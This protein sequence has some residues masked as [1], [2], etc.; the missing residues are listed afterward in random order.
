L[1]YLPGTGAGSVDNFTINGTWS[2]AGYPELQADFDS[3]RHFGGVNMLYADGH[4]KWLHSH[5]VVTEAIPCQGNSG[6]VT[7]WPT[8]VKSAWNPLS[9]G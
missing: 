2:A 6:C 5:E 3:G 4:A 7:S 8:T 9:S 1:R